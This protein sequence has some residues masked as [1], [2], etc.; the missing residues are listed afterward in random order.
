[1]TRHR[2]TQTEI[3]PDQGETALSIFVHPPGNPTHMERAASVAR[4][5]GRR[6]LVVS[7]TRTAAAGQLTQLQQSSAIKQQA[8]GSALNS[9]RLP[10]GEQA[11]GRRRWRLVVG[12][13]RQ[14]V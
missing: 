3:E 10:D 14:E 1:M 13:W 12:Y 9:L 7:S 4:Q 8:R 11:D 6:G 2:E 5:C